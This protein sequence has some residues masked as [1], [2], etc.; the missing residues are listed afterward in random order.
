MI[1][2]H[3]T[4]YGGDSKWIDQDVEKKTPSAG[5]DNNYL[6]SEGKKLCGEIMM[7]LAHVKYVPITNIHSYCKY[8]MCSY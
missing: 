2:Q 5:T 1:L 6:I 7:F 4:T 3:L 8:M